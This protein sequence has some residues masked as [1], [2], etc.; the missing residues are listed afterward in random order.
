M[1]STM[2]HQ[3][4]SFVT[5]LLFA[6]L[7]LVWE[8]WY[9]ALFTSDKVLLDQR[10]FRLLHDGPKPHGDP[11]P[12]IDLVQS[13]CHSLAVSSVAALDAGYCAWVEHGAKRED[14]A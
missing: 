14:P 8:G 10:E 11:G 2:K 3:P 1:P 13:G 7:V 9:M 5:A 12:Q 6:A 4:N